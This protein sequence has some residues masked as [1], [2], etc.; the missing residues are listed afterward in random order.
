MPIVEDILLAHHG[1]IEV[2]SA[3][4]RGTTVRLLWPVAIPGDGDPS[5]D[6]AQLQPENWK[7]TT[8]NPT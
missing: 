4:G 6:N 2:E 8:E 3:E 5:P 1:A 7:P